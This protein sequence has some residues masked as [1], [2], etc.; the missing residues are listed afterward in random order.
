MGGRLMLFRRRQDADAAAVLVVLHRA[1]N[2]REEREVGSLADTS[3]GVKTVADLANE[4]MAGADALAGE[5]LHS[6]ALPVRVAAV[7]ARS[8]TFFMCHAEYPR[9]VLGR[10]WWCFRNATE[11]VPYRSRHGRRVPL[12]KGGSAATWR[13]F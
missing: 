13:A 3:A 12:Q 2:K 4:D 5:T 10:A 9:V 11:V 8:L 7:A 6:A 1:F